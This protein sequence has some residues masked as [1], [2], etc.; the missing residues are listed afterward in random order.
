MVPIL[1][2]TIYSHLQEVAQSIIDKSSSYCVTGSTTINSMEYIRQNILRG[3]LGG[4][5]SVAAVLAG[6][7]CAGMM[8]KYS[9]DYLEGHGITLWELI[10]PLFIFVLIINFN[11]F[12]VTP[13]HSICNIFTRSVER[14]CYVSWGE[15]MMTYVNATNAAMVA[16]MNNALNTISDAWK[17]SDEEEQEIN[18]ILEQYDGDMFAAFRDEAFNERHPAGSIWEQLGNG[19]SYVGKGLAGT[20]K[21]IVVGT[22]DM[23]GTGLLSL[24]NG[25]LFLAMKI[26]LM[27]QQI[28]CYVYLIILSLIGPF[29][30]AIGIVPAFR[31]TIPGWIARYIQVASW[32][33]IGFIILH[34]NLEIMKF[35]TVFTSEYSIGGKY[36]VL[37]AGIVSVASVSAVPKIAAYIIDSTGLNDAHGNVNAYMRSGARAASGA[38]KSSGSSAGKAAVL[39]AARKATTKGLL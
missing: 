39:T 4:F 8:L 18:E 10:R 20:F 13:I 25:L 21:G 19:F 12:V 26:L 34:I 6:I 24:I 32:I 31:S 23:V 9:H 14:Q 33:P 29:A 17:H 11:S 15:F 37:V 7:I 35:L 16:T 5:C 1:D 22:F 38:V 27:C 30:F 2:V 28:Y 3:E 36:V